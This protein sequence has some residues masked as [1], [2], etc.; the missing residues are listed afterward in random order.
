MMP[1]QVFDNPRFIGLW[2][3]RPHGRQR[4]FCA[5]VMVDGEVRET[6]MYSTWSEALHAADGIL[7][8][9]K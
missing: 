6:E 3:Y 1:T 2:T 5:S 9:T 4:Q 7:D 8:S